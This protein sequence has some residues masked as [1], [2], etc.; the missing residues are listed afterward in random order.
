MS[1]L[2]TKCKLAG[3][4]LGVVTFIPL[5]TYAF[6]LGNG[7][8]T[9]FGGMQDFV[10][11]EEFC[12]CSDSNVHFIMDDVTNDVLELYYSPASRIYNNDNIDTPGVQQ[13]GTYSYGGE[14]CLQVDGP[15]CIS[16]FEP[17]GTYGT[18]PG[19]GTSMLEN[20]NP[21]VKSLFS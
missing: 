16:L 11:G 14:P 8:E 10:L 4:L 17:T 21:L 12:D 9:A 6:G 19:T 7:G 20:L 1:D 18:Q 13:L 5:S 15:D 3:I 2:R